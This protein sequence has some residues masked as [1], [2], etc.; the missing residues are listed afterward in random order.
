MP[1][2]YTHFEMEYFATKTGMVL[3]CNR[4]SN[5]SAWK[6]AAAGGQ[7]HTHTR[8]QNSYMNT[9]WYL[10]KCMPV[11]VCVQMN[12]DLF[13]GHIFDSKQTFYWQLLCCWLL[14]YLLPKTLI[15]CVVYFF[16]CFVPS[17]RTAIHTEWPR[18]EFTR[19]KWENAC[20]CVDMN[21]HNTRINQRKR[22]QNCGVQSFISRKEINE[23]SYYSICVQCAKDY[24]CVRKYQSSSYARNRS[25]TENMDCVK[26]TGCIRMC[27]M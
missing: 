19:W 21:R 6:L 26:E 5:L 2:E 4:N 27:T 23:L 10:V 14:C 24:R 8:R 11:C 17:P 7:I 18:N 15:H 12:H 20:V 1:F 9:W 22:E 25:N 3:I 16:V 13:N